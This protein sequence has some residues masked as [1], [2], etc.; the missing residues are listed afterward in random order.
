MQY[1]H[2]NHQKS[3][4]QQPNLS[5]PHLPP[6][7][8]AKMIMIFDSDDEEAVLSKV[9]K[10]TNNTHA[11]PINND[12]AENLIDFNNKTITALPSIDQ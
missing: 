2:Q 8:A 6:K 10:I 7:T 11:V 5:D 1:S 4:Q 3:N 9:D 12:A